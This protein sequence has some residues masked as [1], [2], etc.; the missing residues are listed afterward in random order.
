MK[1]KSMNS[2]EAGKLTIRLL[3]MFI[4]LQAVV[5][6]ATNAVHHSV[7][8]FA[9]VVIS[10][11]SCVLA[12][13]AEPLAGRFAVPMDTGHEPPSRG[14]GGDEESVSP[15]AWMTLLL[16]IIGMIITVHACVSMCASIMSLQFQTANLQYPDPEV[17]RLLWLGLVAPVL[18]LAAG[19]VVT[20]RAK[21]ITRFWFRRMSDVVEAELQNTEA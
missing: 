10:V 6:F 20:F 9:F 4:W 17:K 3:A 21:R 13:I 18:E 14:T 2:R 7:E 1:G 8:T 16:A 15:V 19:L 5:A 11:C 12:A